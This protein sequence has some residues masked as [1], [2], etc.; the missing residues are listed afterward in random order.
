M[1]E[2]GVH[3][4]GHLRRPKDNSAGFDGALEVDLG[5]PRFSDKH[6]TH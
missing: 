2:W 1:G 6:F 5:L 4:M 3:A